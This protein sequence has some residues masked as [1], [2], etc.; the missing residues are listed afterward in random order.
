MRY[1]AMPNRIWLIC[2]TI[3]FKKTP[4]HFRHQPREPRVGYGLLILSPKSRFNLGPPVPLR[5]LE[6]FDSKETKQK[7]QGK[8]HPFFR[9]DPWPGPGSWWICPGFLFAPDLAK[10][11]RYWGL[12]AGFAGD[13][14]Y[15]WVAGGVIPHAMGHP[16][17]AAGWRRHHPAGF[18]GFCGKMSGRFFHPHGGAAIVYRIAIIHPWPF[19]RL[20]PGG[21]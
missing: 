6:K 21:R 2:L 11:T 18:M 10:N 19:W 7:C 9:P 5:L 14:F 4:K 17:M 13:G 15:R 16:P 8:N 1:L 20:F 3:R 12:S